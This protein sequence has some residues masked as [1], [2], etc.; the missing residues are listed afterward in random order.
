LI[1]TITKDLSPAGITYSAD[2][3]KIYS[4]S[5]DGTIQVY[6]SSDFSLI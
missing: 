4:G 6:S 5:L 3:L 1:Q 2:G